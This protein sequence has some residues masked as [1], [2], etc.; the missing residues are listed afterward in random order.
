MG[1]IRPVKLA[2][3]GLDTAHAGQ[4]HSGSA[5]AKNMAICHDPVHYAIEFDTPGI[6]N[7]K[8]IMM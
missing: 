5:K 2:A 3:R 8:S 4:A 7:R 6:D 1:E